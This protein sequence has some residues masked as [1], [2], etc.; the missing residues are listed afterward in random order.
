MMLRRLTQHIREQ[1]WFAVVLDFL[2]VVLGV[3]L[4][5]QATLWQGALAER[6]REGML[7]ERLGEDLLALQQVNEAVAGQREAMNAQFDRA[8]EF[9]RNADPAEANAQAWQ[10]AVSPVLGYPDPVTEFAIYDEIKSTAG[11]SLLSDDE[12]RH[13]LSGFGQWLDNS[14]LALGVVGDSYG[15]AWERI[16]RHLV[17]AQEYPDLVA[18][19][20]LEQRATLMADV[21]MMRTL[22][23]FASF[24]AADIGLRAGELIA[25]LPEAAQPHRPADLD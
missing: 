10:Q 3:F 20:P 9:I 13:E 2:I 21:Q 8:I 12:L 18:A 16:H 11:F 22:A 23:F 17:T 7:L 1:N 24:K 14:K 19:M 15:S 25:L 4:G 6:E 5:F